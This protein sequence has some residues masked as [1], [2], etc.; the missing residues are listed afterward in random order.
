MK[1]PFKT[2]VGAVIAALCL[3]IAAPA[4]AIRLYIEPADQTKFLGESTWIDIFLAELNGEIV[5]AFDLDLTYDPTIVQAT[6]VDLET[7]SVP[8]MGGSFDTFAD[9]SLTSGRVD[10][11]VLSFL[12]DDND[13][14]A[15]QTSDPVYLARINFDTVG[16]GTSALE[17]DFGSPPDVTAGPNQIV[18]R[19]ATPLNFSVESGS[20]TVIQQNGGGGPPSGIPEPSVFV[21]LLG[22]LGILSMLRRNSTAIG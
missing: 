5:S 9:F 22:G 14:A 20:I 15:L 17:F 21:L 12:T 19:N 4:S 7:T 3:T 2:L 8:L 10:F 11:S 1:T 18:G 16:P 13:I 6:S